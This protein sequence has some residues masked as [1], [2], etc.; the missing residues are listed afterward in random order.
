MFYKELYPSVQ[1]FKYPKAGEKNSEVSLHIYDVAN[2]NTKNIDLKNYSDFY[3]ARMKWTNDSNVLCAQLL[4]RHQ[5]NLDL[6]FVDGTS[7]TA[8]VVLNEQFH[9]DQ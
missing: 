7:G 3:I 2:A 9:L 5:D 4:N 6:L 8:K 1:T